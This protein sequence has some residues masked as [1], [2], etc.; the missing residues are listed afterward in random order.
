MD[1][2]RKKDDSD[3]DSY[4]FSQEERIFKTPNIEIVDTSN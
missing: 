1:S 4:E 3:M 2:T